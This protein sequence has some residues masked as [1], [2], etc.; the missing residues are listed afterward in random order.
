MNSCWSCLV[1]IENGAT[2]CPLCG[3]DQTPLPLLP[4][5]EAA[6]LTG[7]KRVVLRWGASV[8]AILCLLGAAAWFTM[9]TNDDDSPARAE[10]AATTALVNI[11]LALSEYAISKG[12]KYPSTLEPL[13]AQAKVPEQDARIKGYAMVYTPLRSE[14]DGLIRGFALLAQ[15]EKENCRN[16]YIDQTGVLRATQERRHA[17]I[18]DPPI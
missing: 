6:V 13:D 15:P 14:S 18:D 7:P 11:R 12:D 1:V 2:V 16:F 10:S 9:Q 8:V 4:V 17:R 3:A 5:A